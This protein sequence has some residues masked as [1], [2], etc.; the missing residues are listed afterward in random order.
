MD[1]RRLLRHE[2][3]CADLAVRLPGGDQREDLGLPGGQAEPIDGGRVKGDA[4]GKVH[5]DPCAARNSVHLGQD[6][7]GAEVRCDPVGFTECCRRPR[8]LSG[9]SCGVGLV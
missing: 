6:G 8:R 7:F 5:A 3:L 9:R 2:Q 4:G 1:A